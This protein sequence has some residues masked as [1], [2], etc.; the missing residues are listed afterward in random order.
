MAQSRPPPVRTYTVATSPPPLSPRTHTNSEKKHHSRRKSGK[1]YVVCEKKATRPTPLS[2]RN[3]PQH[4]TRLVSAGRSSHRDRDEDVYG[5]RDSGESF[6]Q[7]C[8][9]C[10]KQFLP[11]STTLYCSEA[12]RAHDQASSQP[13][14][15]NSY[16]SSPPLSPY[17]NQF[18]YPSTAT[19]ED[20]P[21]I[22]PRFSPTQSRPRSYFNSDP[23]PQI[24]QP[25]A[26]TY[27]TSPKTGCN[28]HGSST[29]LASLRELATALPKSSKS[30]RHSRHDPASPPKSTASSITRTGSGVWDYM[31]FTSS[32]KTTHTPSVTPGNSYSNTNTSYYTNGYAVSQSYGVAGRNK[33]DLYSNGGYGAGAYGYA[34][35]HGAV[36]WFG[37]TGGMGMDR[38]LPPRTASHRP[39]SVDLVTPFS[40]GH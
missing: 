3:T 22:I 13:I 5:G 1:D 19:Y 10:E 4:T 8:M 18:A 7:F 2:R 34:K 32:S 36:G 6:P 39:K 11:A 35:S 24:Y 38:P 31:P 20:G 40:T 29:A 28:D 27:S 33:E 37:S 21:D 26:N 16:S 17:T 14:R 15:N 30:G 9:T 12:C 25:S 23:Y